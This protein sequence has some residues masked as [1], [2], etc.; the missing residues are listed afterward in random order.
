MT[1]NAM[2]IHKYLRMARAFTLAWVLLAC[3][4]PAAAQASASQVAVDGQQ[5]G[6]VIPVLNYHSIGV[7]PGN[8]Y[9]LHPDMFARQMDYF[10]A[11]HYTPLTLHDFVRIIEKK[12]P[13][14]ERPVLLTFDDGYANNAEVA[15]PI[16]QRHRFPATL[17]LSPGF[18]GQP[19][20]LSWPQVQEL[21][22]AGWDI[23]PHGLTHPHLTQLSVEQQREEITESRRRIEQALGKSVDVFAYP[24]GEYNE[25]TLKILKEAA[26]RYAFTTKEGYASSNQ[27]P[28]ELSRIVVHGED[29]FATWVQKL[30]ASLVS[31]INLI[32]FVG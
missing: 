23:A 11:H 29:D 22:A 2:G 27:S 1:M 7:E 9:V 15:L 28:Y 30:T 14:P 26:Y 25:E 17:F 4:A 3:F 12:Q 8:T 20:Y 32:S 6:I 5:H 21:S 19:G 10:A 24:F 16:L 13:S 18:I 31:L